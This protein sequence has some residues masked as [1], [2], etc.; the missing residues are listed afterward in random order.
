MQFLSSSEESQQLSSFSSL[1]LTFEVTNFSRSA[2]K[3]TGVEIKKIS[4]LSGAHK[5]MCPLDMML[6]IDNI[7]IG[8]DGTGNDI[9]CVYYHLIN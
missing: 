6:A 7:A 9:L 8:N 5:I 4:S 1:G 3:M 2:L